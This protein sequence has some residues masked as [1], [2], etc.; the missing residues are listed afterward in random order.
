MDDSDPPLGIYTMPLLRG[1]AYLEVLGDEPLLEAFWDEFWVAAGIESD[2]ERQNIR[3]MAEVAGKI[4][5]IL[6]YG[7]QRTPERRPSV[8]LATSEAMSTM[9]MTLLGD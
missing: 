2:D 1:V 8:K 7:F 6:R 5:A 4:G 9:L 3:T